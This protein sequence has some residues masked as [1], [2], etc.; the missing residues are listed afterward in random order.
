MAR[1]V[2]HILRQKYPSSLSAKA[3]AGIL[4]N[5]SPE[6]NFATSSKIPMGPGDKFMKRLLPITGL[7]FGLLCLTAGAQG[8]QSQNDPNQQQPNA[9]TPGTP[10]TF[11]TDRQDTGAQ[12]NRTDQNR[13]SKDPDADKPQV[14][15]DPDSV[16]PQDTDRDR[17]ITH[18]ANKDD[19]TPQATPNDQTTPLPPK[20][21]RDYDR[22]RNNGSI[23]SNAG[24]QKP[25]DHDGAQDDQAQKADRD[26]RSDYQSQLQAA[27]QQKPNLSG[28][29]VNY[30]DTT[31]ELTGVVPT[32]N[33]KHE[34]RMIAQNYANGRKVVDHI[35]VTGKNN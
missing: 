30:T 29:Q 12:Q 35:T 17:D 11:P 9:S 24:E 1:F 4:A 31:V 16:H 14:D 33:E 28:V 27:L 13:T 21:D 10:P 19:Q 3:K 25:P 32:G 8:A 6:L 22:D 34:A 20:S 26:H 23:G 15:Q 7:S 2:P 5:T 18:P